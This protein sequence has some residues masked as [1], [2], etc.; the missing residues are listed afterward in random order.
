MRRRKNTWWN[1][2]LKFSNTFVFYIHFKRSKETIFL[3]KKTGSGCV[4]E[5]HLYNGLYYVFGGN[6]LHDFPL[7]IFP[8]VVPALFS[9][10]PRGPHS[11]ESASASSHTPYTDTKKTRF[12]VGR[13]AVK[14]W[15]SQFSFHQLE[16]KWLLHVC[17]IPG[18]E[19]L[20]KM[21]RSL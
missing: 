1:R 15:G 11:R 6:W 4:F 21:L 20:L 14:Y 9:N 3:N 10:L 12:E 7:K 19:C 16:R 13:V 17:M 8:R 5:I 2:K 18:H